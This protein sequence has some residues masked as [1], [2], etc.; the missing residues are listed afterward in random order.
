MYWK[1]IYNIVEVHK[2][3]KEKREGKNYR[4]KRFLPKK[5]EKVER[6]QKYGMSY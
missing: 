3:E 1:N 6:E 5:E 4:K 2:Q